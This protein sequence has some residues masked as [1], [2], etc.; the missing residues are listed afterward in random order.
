MFFVKKGI[1]EYILPSYD[2]LAFMTVKHGNYF[3]EID[4]L[5]GQNRKFA[6]RAQTELEVLVL[7]INHYNKFISY[8]YKNVA[9]FLR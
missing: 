2:N 3:G 8:Q 7:E 1:V 6:T 5:F 4:M 9:Q